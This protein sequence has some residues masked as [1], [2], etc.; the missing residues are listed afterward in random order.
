MEQLLVPS[1][2]SETVQASARVDNL[3]LRLFTY[4]PEPQ[5][6]GSGV[7]APAV[8]PETFRKIAAS[9]AL[10][11]P[12][13]L[14]QVGERQRRLLTAAGATCVP[15]RTSSPYT[16]GLSEPTTLDAGFTVMRPL[17]LPVVTSAMVKGVCKSW[18][19]ELIGDVWNPTQSEQQEILAGAGLLPLFGGGDQAGTANGAAQFF[20]AVPVAVTGTG[21]RADVTT[22]HHQSWYSGSGWP[23][24]FE[25]PV[26]VPFLT[27]DAGVT[28]VFG[29][30]V[31]GTLEWS[32]DVQRA[33]VSGDALERLATF[34]VDHESFESPLTLIRSVLVSAARYHGFGSQVA[35]GYGRFTR[36]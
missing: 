31:E 5:P 34:G 21:L 2:T 4:V 10:L 23:S 32:A 25:N 30:L 28:F 9:R 3:Y 12:G 11:D 16:S 36:I 27:V 1:R 24:G 7:A 19:V 20:D 14:A 29:L 17:G 15:L 22:V 6:K 13:V 33:Q 35:R 26:P 18:L 8:K